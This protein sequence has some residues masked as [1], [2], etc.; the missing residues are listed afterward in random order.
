[1]KIFAGS[2]NGADKNLPHSP[3]CGADVQD[4]IARRRRPFILAA[5]SWQRSP[6]RPQT[7]YVS[8]KKFYPLMAELATRPIFGRFRISRATPIAQQPELVESTANKDNRK[9]T[10]VH[11]A[12]CILH[13]RF[14]IDCVTLLPS[15]KQFVGGGGETGSPISRPRKAKLRRPQKRDPRQKKT[16]LASQEGF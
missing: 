7:K 13:F 14:C 15:D 2:L 1:M 6:C 8:C 3:R 4:A 10:M 11:F 16:F 5:N 12:F 9:C